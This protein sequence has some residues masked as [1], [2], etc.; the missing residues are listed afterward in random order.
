[1]RTLTITRVVHASVLVDFDGSAILT[2]PWYSERS[3]YYPGEPVGIPLKAL[4]RL[5]GVVVSHRHYDHYDMDA[6]AAY[7]DKS[8]PFAV[9]RGTAVPALTAGFRTVMELDPWETVSLGG[10]KVTAAPAKHGVPE[11]TYIL[12]AAGFTVFLSGDTLLIPELDEVARRFPHVSPCR[13]LETRRGRT[14]A[15]MPKANMSSRTVTKMKPSAARRLVSMRP[16]FSPPVAG[17]CHP[18]PLELVH[19]P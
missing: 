17:T 3:G 2:D 7:P 16:L 1:M 4:P 12:E 8:V 18:D 13:K 5:V 11:N 14:G 6:F 9:K 10:V 15:M 19:Q